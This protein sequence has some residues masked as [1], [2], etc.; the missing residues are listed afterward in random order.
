MKRMIWE[1]RE[2]RRTEEDRLISRFTRRETEQDRL[3]RVS[4]KHVDPATADAIRRALAA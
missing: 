3:A 1:T 4:R 2:G